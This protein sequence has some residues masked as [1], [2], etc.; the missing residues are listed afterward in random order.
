MPVELDDLPKEAQIAWEISQKLPPI[1]GG[2]DSLLVGFDYSF[3]N[4]VMNWYSIPKKD[5]AVYYELILICGQTIVDEIGK[6][7]RAKNK[8]DSAIR[9]K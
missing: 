8:A 2:L 5:K 1:Y 7:Q 9:N 4:D 3:L 6:Q